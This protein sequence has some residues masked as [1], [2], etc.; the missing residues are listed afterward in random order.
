MTVASASALSGCSGLLTDSES[1]TVSTCEDA[2]SGWSQFQRDVANSGRSTETTVVPESLDSIRRVDDRHGGAVLTDD[3]LVFGR[4][5]TLYAYD[6]AGE[7]QRWSVDLGNLR[8]TP[9]KYCDAVL[10]AALNGVY[11]IDASDGSVIWET[12]VGGTMGPVVVAGE[13]VV[14]PSSSRV[15]AFAVA[16]GSD[17]WASDRGWTKHGVA[18]TDGTVFVTGGD[19]TSGYVAT[20]DLDS[21]EKLWQTRLTQTAYGPPT[22]DDGDV[23]VV[24]YGG[25]AYRIDA[26]GGEIRWEEPVVDRSE[27]AP[28]VTDSLVVVGAGWADRTYALDAE[29]GEQR[30]ELETGPVLV[31]PV[32]ADEEIF[33]GTMNRGLF[34]LDH[35]ETVLWHR[36]EPNVGSP[37]A[38]HDGALAFKSRF[39]DFE[40]YRLGP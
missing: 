6:A 34:A 39:P 7:T 11:A 2:A 3:S 32:A 25:T 5:E 15:R 27:S 14:V 1:E 12:E 4:E 19:M 40:L 38:V 18:V 10:A 16:D 29:T 9:A 30:W 31:P 37:M 8:V 17:R 22:C 20:F 13:T 28:L 23:F 24:D 26:D 35:E 21:G 33:V 36:E